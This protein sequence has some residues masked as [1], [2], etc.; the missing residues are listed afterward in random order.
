MHP[1]EVEPALRK[2]PEGATSLVGRGE[3]GGDESICPAHP[4]DGRDGCRAPPTSTRL[5]YNRRRAQRLDRAE[6]TY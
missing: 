2:I 5:R 3:E 1:A 6:A 4:F